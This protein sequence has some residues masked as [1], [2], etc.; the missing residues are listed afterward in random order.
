MA[1]VT[2]T[3]DSVGNSGCETAPRRV[4]RR[5][6]R[7]APPPPRVKFTIRLKPNQDVEKMRGCIE[8][9]LGTK[10]AKTFPNLLQFRDSIWTYD[11]SD[12]KARVEEH[13]VDKATVEKRMRELAE[14]HPVGLPIRV[15]EAVPDARKF[16]SRIGKEIVE[17]RFLVLTLPIFMRNY[18]RKACNP[19]GMLF[20]AAYTL[21]DSCGFASVTPS[22]PHPIGLQSASLD[23]LFPPR[24]EPIQTETPN[25][26]R[27]HLFNIGAINVAGNATI[28]ALSGTGV[29][30]GHVDTGWTRHPQLNFN[31]TA[32]GG[33]SPNF[34]PGTD[35]N[36]LN[37]SAAS[38]IE[39]VPAPSFPLTN[40]YHGTRTAS[41][42]VS[43]YNGQGDAV[44]GLVPGASIVSIRCVRDVVILSPEIDDELIA[45]AIVAAVMRGAQVISISLGGYPCEYLHWAI[46]W[47][48]L[49]NVIVVAAAGNYW[50][51][52]VYPAGYPEC[53]GVGGS[54][55]DD[56]RW[57]YSARN[58]NGLPQ[59][60]ISAPAEFVRHA[61][62]GG[63]QLPLA[64]S[65]SGTSFATAIVA[66]AAA[67][68]LQRFGRTTLI[69][70]L[71]GR[72]PLQV[73]FQA[74]LWVTRRT[75]N[76]W[77]PF[78][79]GPGILN[80]PGLLSPV[81]MPNPM[82]FSLPQWFTALLPAVGNGSN[83]APGPLLGALGLT[84]NLPPW[85]E[86]V[87]D[88]NA[89]EVITDFSEEVMHLIMENPMVSD[90][91]DASNQTTQ[92]AQEAAENAANAV[93]DAVETAQE[94]AEEAAETA[95]KVTEAVVDTI[96][97]TA[98]DA[99]STVAGW[100]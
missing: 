11:P 83:L 92:A 70:A 73:L 20:D 100:F 69:N 7:E 30:I 29:T 80:L 79:D 81:T 67:L 55:A 38:A 18:R 97:D 59:I 75:P 96:S 2:Q 41:L 85:L 31:S 50:P 90:L 21:R 65:K 61:T 72:A 66:A 87:F 40:P 47:A 88:G 23:S 54:T 26:A 77:D 1:E 5:P 45:A 57:P 6:K 93:G 37:P 35:L 13:Y 39:P 10:L 62:W 25:T 12:R 71:S 34:T 95:S 60:D 99:L 64:D 74:H 32:T 82:T 27:W 89:E 42:M 53:I 16:T 84:G 48:V 52:V 15:K 78:L 86:A 68:W 17:Q 9:T 76:G 63:G 8:I 24:G 91:I 58:W 98:S 36:L 94:T 19:D 46:Q 33:V 28:P 4:C 51:L 44:A 56:V 22:L 49:N 43:S 14:G 3:S